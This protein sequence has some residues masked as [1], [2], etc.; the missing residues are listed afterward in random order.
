LSEYHKIEIEPYFD[1]LIH[2][3]NQIRPKLETM[4]VDETKQRAQQFV[5]A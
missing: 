5:E 4:S 3:A 2:R 1:V